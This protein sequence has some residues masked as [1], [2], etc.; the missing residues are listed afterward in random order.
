MSNQNV[1]WANRGRGGAKVSTG[2]GLPLPNNNTDASATDSSDG[3]VTQKASIFGERVVRR[4]A[5]STGSTSTATTPSESSKE[6][7]AKTNPSASKEPSKTEAEV[8]EP[9]QADPKDESSTNSDPSTKSVE[10]KKNES[11]EFTALPAHLKKK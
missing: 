9:P 5:T 6:E 7:T 10:E 3:S 1:P 2:R 4:S 11:S 8:V